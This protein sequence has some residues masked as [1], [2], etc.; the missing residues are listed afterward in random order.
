MD[1]SGTLVGDGD[2]VVGKEERYADPSEGKSEGEGGATIGISVVD[3]GVSVD[4]R[5]GEN[6]GGVDEGVGVGVEKSSD[7]EI[8]VEEQKVPKR[9]FN[10]VT[11]TS[12]VSVAGTVTV[13]VSPE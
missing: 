6:G 9:V 4:V 12:T 2:E 7:D 1:R 11:W 8:G 13:V 10:T 3:D 5:K